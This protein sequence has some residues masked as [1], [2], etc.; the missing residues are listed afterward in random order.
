MTPQL[1]TIHHLQKLEN[2]VLLKN[3]HL[4][5]NSRQMRVVHTFRMNSIA[6]IHGMRPWR[7][8][9]ALKRNRDS[10]ISGTQKGNSLN[11]DILV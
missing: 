6:S 4:K 8:N 10:K 2:E 9:N 1:R 7:N 11:F 5:S 3:M